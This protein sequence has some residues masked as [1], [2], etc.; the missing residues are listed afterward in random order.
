MG[1]QNP[2]ANDQLTEQN[3]AIRQGGRPEYKPTDDQR[4]SVRTMVEAG[5]AKTQI[6]AKLGI[7]RVTLRKHFAEEL[8]RT[9]FAAAAAEL[10]FAAGP[11]PAKAA[12]PA[13]RPEFEATY[14]QREDVR[15][16]K[17]D[18]WSDDRF[19]AQLGIA[20]TTL[21]K[22]FADELT[23]G[24]DQVRTRNLRNLQRAADNGSVGAC[25]AL[26]RLTGLVPPGPPPAPPPE[27]DEVVPP[28]EKLGKKAQAKLA[29]LTA[30]DD[31]SWQGLM[32]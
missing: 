16:W 31:T 26:L 13:G 29:A 32:Q 5:V 7:S 17:A 19:A 11:A 12:A 28:E 2:P 23:H 3:L 8:S 27:Q 25:N 20:R 24:A 4:G 15:L 1:E 21:L 6:A 14:R 22:H 30:E 10:D 18:D 9:A